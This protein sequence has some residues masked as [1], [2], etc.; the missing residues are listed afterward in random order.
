[1]ILDLRSLKPNYGFADLYNLL[2]KA[3]TSKLNK[4]VEILRGIRGVK[5]L[6]TEI[7]I[8]WKGKDSIS[9]SAL[10][11]YLNRHRVIIAFDEA[12]KLRGSRSRMILNAPAH[13]YDFNENI[14]FIFTGSE[15]GLLYDFL[16]VDNPES[17]LYGRFMH[18][19]TIER[20][21]YDES[22]EFLKEEFEE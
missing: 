4:F 5:I 2:S 21:S 6:G 12:Q 15:M 7:E 18:E 14:T 20:F 8:R 3:F 19:I 10:L 16:D 17:P 13:S 11:D 9:F 22:I 1:M